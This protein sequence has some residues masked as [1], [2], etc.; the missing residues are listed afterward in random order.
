MSRRGSQHS[1]FNRPPQSSASSSTAGGRGRGRGRGRGHSAPSPPVQTSY[2]PPAQTSSAASL[3]PSTA[4]PPRAVAPVPASAGPGPSR[5]PP[6]QASPA[7]VSGSG[8]VTTTA[9]SPAVHSV[10]SALE[11]QLTLETSAP[12]SSKA[13]RY[14][15]RPGFGRAGRKIQIRANHFQVQ[16]GVQ[17]IYH[18]DVAITPEITSKKV[19]RDVIDLLV[20]AHRESI[21]GNR[22]PA[23]DGRKSLFTAGPLP[24]EIKEFKVKLGDNDEPRKKREREFRVTIRFASKTD[25]HHLIQFLSRR[26]LDCPQETIQ[27]LDVVLRATPSENFDVVGRS[28]FSPALGP[29]GPLGS[30][31]EYW[32]GYYQSLRPTQMGLSLNIDVSA[33]AFY[34]AIPVLDFISKNFRLDFRRPL[35]DQDRVKIKKALRGIKVQVNHGQNIR[36]YKV[37][38]VTKEPLRALMFNDDTGTKKS[39]VQYFQEKYNISLQYT[40]LS[41]LQAG[42]DTKPIFLPMELCQIVA[43]QRYTKKL[44]EDQVTALLKATCQRPHE[45]EDSIRKIVRQSKFSAD[46]FARHFDIQVRED[47]VTLDARVLPPPMLKY[48]GSGGES[49]VQPK[50][51]QWN[52]INK[53]MIAGGTVEHWTCLNFSG[54]I[55][56]DLPYQHCQDLAE[57]CNSKGMRFKESPALPI[58]S[59]PSGQIENAL[60]NLH[61]QCKQAN[62]GLQLLII[63]LPDVKGS[64][65][66]IKRICE[67]ELGIVSQCCQ[68]KQLV[69][70]NRQQYL[71]NLALKIN[72]KVGGTNTI[73]NDAFVRRIPHVSDVPTIIFGADVTHP[74]PGEDSSPSIAAVVASMDWPFVTRYKGVVSAQKHRDEMIHDLYIGDPAGG[75]PHSGIIRELFRAFRI[76]T[77]RKPE[78]I[79][80]YRDGVSEGQFNQVLLYEMDAIRKACNSLEENYLPPVTFVVVQKRHHTRLFPANHGA[81]D[82]T[83]RSGNIMPGTVVDTTICHP[84]EFDFYL[85]SHAGIQG[86]SRPTHYHVLYDENKFTADELQIL[87]NN[88]CYTY[89]RCTRSVSIVPPAYYAHLAAFRARYYIEGDASDAGS[90][91]GGK[92]VLASFEV[93]LPS[94]KGNVANV[95]FFC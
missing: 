93:K 57:M 78:R 89:A 95:M 29:K 5:P 79:I 8:A 26:Q 39:V 38:A 21:L 4:A 10:T 80:F 20:R 64:Y 14:P 34:E 15:D 33:R 82:T 72:V 53:R 46:K 66:K 59:S 31:T 63:I 92:G 73:L 51:G 7:P 23:Y 69:K 16:V 54:R 84:R 62:V 27:A 68:P 3:A 67:T 71:E 13:N 35:P 25:L 85:N 48:H 40:Q 6:V 86:T 70:P 74:Q 81:R 90:S 12:S 52:M 83:D 1:D 37:T 49:Q 75:I 18:Y 77:N 55:H 28:F 9:P 65:G 50:M 36:R 88:L 42:S 41:A 2:P 76:S 19:S 56:R 17:E 47:P 87:T 91:T 24:F 11:K 22:M 43:G 44:N 61:K 32:R 45:R 30:G 60:V 94:V 58:T